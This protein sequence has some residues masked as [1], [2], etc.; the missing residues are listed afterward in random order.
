MK[1]GNAQLKLR[2]SGRLKFLDK[3]GRV[4]GESD[5]VSTSP[6]RQLAAHQ[7]LTESPDADTAR[8]IQNRLT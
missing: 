1:Q 6:V 7:Q 4:V 8:H 3:D 5:F 2:V